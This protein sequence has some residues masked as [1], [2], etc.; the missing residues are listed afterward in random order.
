MSWIIWRSFFALVFLCIFH[1]VA[2]G[3]FFEVGT[4]CMGMVYIGSLLT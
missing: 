3:M 1:E 2:F 4:H